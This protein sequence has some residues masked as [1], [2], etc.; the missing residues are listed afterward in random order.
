MNNPFLKKESPTTLDNVEW[1][2]LVNDQI[3]R[4]NKSLQPVIFYTTIPT[5]IELEL[6]SKL[7]QEQ[8]FDFKYKW[9]DDERREPY[10]ICTLD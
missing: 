4:R 10:W 5:E 6:T 9:E 3:M 7:L 1:I 8:G 2:T